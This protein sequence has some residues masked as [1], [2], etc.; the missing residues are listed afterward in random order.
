VE[1]LIIPESD[2]AAI[3]PMALQFDATVNAVQRELQL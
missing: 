3:A 1:E 2:P